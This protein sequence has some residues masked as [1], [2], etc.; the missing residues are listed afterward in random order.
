MQIGAVAR[1]VGLTVDAI[2]FY[3]RNAL[4]PRAARTP[5]GFRRYAEDDVQ[6]LEFIRRVQTLGFSL[7]EIRSL[8]LLRR[9]RRQPCAPV[10]RRLQNKLQ[11]VRSKLVDLRQLEKELEAV[12]RGCEHQ[13]RKRS[14]RC[15]LLGQPDGKQ[16]HG[17]N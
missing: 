14:T 11:Q 7:R 12:L 4:M 9:S 16:R 10:C 6:S 15:P 8:L 17:D 13:V 5:G 1:R 2:R 3:E